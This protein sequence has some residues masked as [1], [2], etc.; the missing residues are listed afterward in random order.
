MKNRVFLWL[1][2]VLTWFPV[3]KKIIFANTA[4]NRD[5]LKPPLWQEGEYIETQ[6]QFASVRFGKGYTLAYGGC[7]PIALYNAMLGLGKPLSVDGF[8]QMLEELQRR[9]AT[10]FGKYGTHPTALRRYLQEQN[11]STV[12]VIGADHEGFERLE[13]NVDVWVTVVFNGK[14]LSD[15][16][17]IVCITRTPEGR[18]T[19][20]NAHQGGEY[21]T[22]EEAVSHISVQGATALYTIGARLFEQ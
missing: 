10:W 15:Q 21:V 16:L 2:S 6:R 18:F 1:W 4:W 12:H 20:H 9:G 8:L 22:L 11:F 14:K 7:G 5:V 17:H 3:P 13:Q 19:P